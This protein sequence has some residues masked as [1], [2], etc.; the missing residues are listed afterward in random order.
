MTPRS[1]NNAHEYGN[2]KDVAATRAAPD[3]G[4][5][6]TARLRAAVVGGA[7]ARLTLAFCGIAALS[8]FLAT[9]GPRELASARDTAAH[10]AAAELPWYESSISVSANWLPLPQ[11]P[12]SVL[13]PAGSS[14]IGQ[15]LD[16]Q[17]AAPITVPRSGVRFWFDAAPQKLSTAAP[18]AITSAGLPSIQVG[19]DSGLAADARLISGHMPGAASGGPAGG[20][21]LVLQ[22]AV[23]QPTAARYELHPGS[24]MTLVLARSRRQA[25]L[26]VTGIVAPRPGAAFWQ[27]TA[28]V[29]DPVGLPAGIAG[30][31]DGSRGPATTPATTWDSGAFVG[32][33]EMQAAQWL[34]ASKAIG[35]DWYFPVSLAHVSPA[36]AP[37]LA[38]KVSALAASNVAP[39]AMG[40]FSF[41][42]V[43]LGSELP[44]ALTSIESQLSE[45]TSID[46]L[47]VG[48]IFAGS[49][50]LM[51]LCGGIAADRYAPEFALKRARGAS[52]GQIVGQGLLRSLGAAGPGVVAGFALA[53]LAVSNGA[54]PTT[55][56]LL[57]LLTAVIAVASVPARLTWRLRRP[58]TPRDAD[59][60]E[61]VAP[62]R[63]LRRLAAEITVVLA[64]VAAVI[65]LRIS[66]TGPGNAL[67]LASPVLIAAAASIA[68][69]RLY[70]IP[71]RALLPLATR[72]RGP[73]GFLGLASAGRSGL[74]AILPALVLVLT[75]TLAA[76]GWMLAATVTS[77]Q[78]ASSWMSLGADAVITV[79]H[80]HAISIAAQRAVGA[81]PGVRHSALV[82]VTG[83]TTEFAP[84]LYAA[85]QS[86]FPVGL[87]VVS[88]GQYA[89]LASSTPWAAF[90]AFSLARRPGAVPILVSDG[91]AAAEPGQ[92][93]TNTRQV[94][95]LGG[96]RL[97]VVVAGTISVTPAFPG[98]GSYVVMPQWAEADFPSI[99]GPATLLVTGSSIATA[100]LTRAADQ[101]MP[102]P[103]IVLRSQL[104]RA[105]QSAVANYAVRLFLLSVWASAAL[106]AFALMFGLAAT[107]QARRQLRRRLSAF[108]MSGRQI[109]ALSL[110]DPL[111]L[112]LVAVLGMVLAALT[113]ILISGKAINLA[114]LT[115][116]TSA[117]G[118]SLSLPA[119]LIA[120]AAAIILALAAMAAE[121]TLAA[122]ADATTA[123]R[124][125]EA[126]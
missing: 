90:P 82:Y 41:S 105:L 103:T 45:T 43:T 16:R 19:Y 47:V 27:S 81:V 108:G 93:A 1:A 96:I 88:P 29:A 124:T 42:S 77:G 92:S 60:D 104:L 30:V 7:G 31:Q 18:S 21:P 17:F 33:A 8:A 22:V 111:A 71:V 99:S 35:G 120:A 91:A 63:S 78:I 112:L 95:E 20:S 107:S 10:E 32:P 89:A 34:L 126:T 70:P 65:T 28:A 87:A 58:V 98:G 56:W 76:F 66:G 13:T 119:I 67:T 9:A 101:T 49:L 59:R 74:S 86:G 62:R 44:G 38:A 102:S 116:A 3:Q 125:E 68:V 75:M 113:L 50:L 53:L 4:P 39:S 15:A 55:G 94:L 46:E 117:T 115:G 118:V 80:N 114:A 48:G 57:L 26:Q 61:I 14:S 51:L 54:A 52:L 24:V 110:T 40:S 85:H 121:N 5:V 69:A 84:S 6:V 64:A 25:R 36:A 79:S 72:R 106:S 83:G 100:A 97:P 2:A 23:T 123:P 122:R 73:V 109:R 37:A 11:T 12:T